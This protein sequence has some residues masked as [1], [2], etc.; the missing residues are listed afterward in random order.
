[1]ARG[2]AA[3]EGATRTHTERDDRSPSAAERAR[4][5]VEGNASAALTVP[6]C[7][8]APGAG[9]PAARA[10]LPDGD[11]LLLVAGGCPGAR[12]A[13]YAQDDDLA[14]VL[15]IT[16][17]APVSVPHRV[18]GRAWVAGWLT[19]VGN[20]DRAACALL[21]AERCPVGGIL[22]LPDASGNPGPAGPPSGDGS[23]SAAGPARPAWTLLR[24]EV[25]EVLV[26][27]LW[28]AEHVEPDAFAAAHGDPLAAYE[29]ELLQHLA[30]AHGDQVRGLCSLLGDRSP[31]CGALDPDGG[32]DGRRGDAEAFGAVPVALDRFGLRVRFRGPDGL[33]DARFEFPEPVACREG[34]RR[35]MHTLFDAASSGHG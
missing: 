23:G 3:A 5:L 6:G 16:D 15:E 17:V 20:S 18:R 28:G 21:L 34:L 33:F 7:G 11:V 27:D 26:D 32:T 22:G 19:P 12:L 31:R 4:T 35:A 1:M 29:T 30:A 14:A 2:R 8:P 24:L 13:S 25:G 10:V 9:V